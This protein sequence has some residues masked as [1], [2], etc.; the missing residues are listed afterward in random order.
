MRTVQVGVRGASQPNSNLVNS[1]A[2]HVV[3][4]TELEALERARLSLLEQLRFLGVSAVPCDDPATVDWWLV[5][6][7][8]AAGS[9]AVSV[10]PSRARA[11]LQ[12]LRPCIVQLVDVTAGSAEVDD[13]DA[14]RITELFSSVARV[15]RVLP[16]ETDASTIVGAVAL[17]SSVRQGAALEAN[18]SDFGGGPNDPSASRGLARLVGGSGSMVMLRRMVAK[19]APT[20]ASVLILGETGTGKEVAARSLHEASPRC[21][22]PFVAVNCGAIPEDLLESE[23]FGHE[24]GAFTGA[25]TSRTGRFELAADGTLFLDEIGDMPLTMQVKLLRVLQERV[26]ERVGSHKPIE[27][28][29]RIVAATHRRLDVAV[30]EGRFREDLFYRLCVFPIDLP[31][32]R[33]RIVDLPIL[34]TVLNR[35]LADSGMKPASFLPDALRVLS[36]YRWPGNVRELGNVLEQLAILY[37]GQWVSAAM[38]PSRL[39]AGN[40]A[41]ASDGVQADERDLLSNLFDAPSESFEE[42]GAFDDAVW[43]ASTV[44]CGSDAAD[45]ANFAVQSALDAALVVSDRSCSDSTTAVSALPEGVALKDHLLELETRW[46]AEALERHEGVVAQ[47]ARALGMRRTTLVERMRRLG[48]SREGDDT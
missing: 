27:C 46:I 42:S 1:F 7:Q 45:G 22:A 10:D 29:A 44:G 6:S 4:R 21:N 33:E 43:D 48:L 20:D 36:A 38:L 35:R 3:T 15:A 8:M 37:P 40:D 14:G 23:L 47:A 9:S 13:F 41:A 26:F 39:R 31:A 19:V 12:A 25:Y 34:I 2:Q 32:L 16:V 5:P 11:S 17:L 28:R 30:E 18:H 24:K